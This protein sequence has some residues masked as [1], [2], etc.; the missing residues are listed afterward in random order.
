M[1]RGLYVITD[2]TAKDLEERVNQALLG[3]ARVVQY[4]DKIHSEPERR[5][6]AERLCRRCRAAGALFIV[7]DSPQLALQCDADGVHLGQGDIAI[8]EARLILGRDK[9]IGIST[10]TVEQALKAEGQGA[11]YIGL[12]SM[13]PTSSKHDAQVVGIDALHRVRRAVKIPIVA[14]GGIGR[15]QAAELIAAGADAVAVI[16]AI[17]QAEDAALAARELALQ[18]NAREGF[19]RGRVLTVAG[20]D[21]SGGAGIQ[22]DLKTIA[23]LGSYGTSALTAL[24]AQNTLG[25][26]AIHPVPADFVAEQL[27]A[28]LEDVG[29]DTLKTGMLLNADTVAVVS[30]A[31]HRHRLLSVVDPVMIAKGG[32]ALL[33]REAADAVRDLLLPETYLLTPNLPEAQTLTGL[34]IGSLNDMEQAAYR[35]QEMGAHHV[36]VKGGHLSGDAVDVL[37]VGK[38]LYRFARKRVPTRNTHGTGCTYS[39]AI[40]SFLAQ[41]KPLLQAVEAAKNFITAAILAARPLGSGNGPVNHWQAAQ[42]TLSR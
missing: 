16:S 38:K 7:N 6:L 12:G 26:R 11:D 18:F 10:R 33:E 34:S 29:T 19:P 28:I 3:G 23:L 9:L 36:L 30:R 41:G 17:F 42:E 39:A 5:I 40:A 20:S 2:A 35:L 8:S 22:A 21:S 4:R 15:E 14:I 37:L 24:T 27:N 32:A 25:V 13:Y 1:L 31:I